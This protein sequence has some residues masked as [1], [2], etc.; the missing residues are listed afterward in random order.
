MSYRLHTDVSWSRTRDDLNETF[1]KWRVNDWNIIAEITPARADNWSQTITERTITLRYTHAGGREVRLTMGE[2][3]RAVDNLR[4]LYLAL[5]AM[6]LNEARGL[7]DTM[8]D[9]Y[10]QLAAPADA[11][12]P[13]EVL[14]IRPDADDS[15]VETAYKARANITHPD[16]GGTDAAFKEVQDAY[17]R[18]NKERD[19]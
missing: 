15:M 18:I 5:N 3:D 11:I 7:A 8:Q 9:A 14:Q 4:V 6:R 16:K 19:A 2:Q 1:R 10:L 13:Y 12:D 17:E